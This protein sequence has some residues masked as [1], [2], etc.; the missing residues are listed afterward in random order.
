MID[1]EDEGGD[2]DEA[3]AEVDTPNS[4][5]SQRKGQL[6]NAR[7]VANDSFVIDDGTNDLLAQ[8]PS[9]RIDWFTLWWDSAH[10]HV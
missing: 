7:R 1:G 8:C 9:T 3:A 6:G 10:A 2:G 4:Q 5:F